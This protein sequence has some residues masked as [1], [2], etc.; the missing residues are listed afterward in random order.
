MLRLCEYHRKHQNEAKKRSDLKLRDAR[1][2]KKRVLSQSYG[3]IFPTLSTMDACF[4]DVNFDVAITPLEFSVDDTDAYSPSGISQLDFNNWSVLSSS[5]QVD[6]EKPGDD[7]LFE[8]L[9]IEKWDEDDVKMLYYY[10]S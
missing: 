10:T 7:K 4:E 8:A 9:E 5:T 3:T 1:A 2:K 6:M